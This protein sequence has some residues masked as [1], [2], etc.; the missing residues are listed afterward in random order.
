MAT[1]MSLIEKA[2]ARVIKEIEK[3]SEQEKKLRINWMKRYH[4]FIRAAKG[5]AGVKSVITKKAG[6]FRSIIGGWA[7]ESM[8]MTK[9]RD[10]KRAEREAKERELQELKLQA[11]KLKAEIEGVSRETDEIVEQVFNLNDAVVAAI[12]ARQV[13][14]SNHVFGRLIKADG[15][16]HSQVTFDSADG[17]RRV[18]VLVNHITKVQ[19][20]L[21]NAAMLE[22]DKFFA[23]FGGEGKEDGLEPEVLALYKLTRDILI[24]RQSF[25]VGPDLYRFL[26]VE[27]DEGVFPELYKAQ[28]LLRRSLRSEKTTSYV[29]LYKRTSTKGKWEALPLH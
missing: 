12:E 27:I 10:A 14:L 23:R 11:V 29:R 7:E 2:M 24:A 8:R 19:T 28:M 5:L 1:K 9:A 13:Y 22:I 15:T 3:L 6:K 20:D 26:G 25:K 17:L 4:R 21:A 16:L 18:V